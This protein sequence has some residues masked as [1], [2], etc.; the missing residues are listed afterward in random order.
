MCQSLEKAFLAKIA[1]MPPDEVELQPAAKVKSRVKPP[2]AAATTTATGAAA[3]SNNVHNLLG[4]N[5]TTPAT[6]AQSMASVKEPAASRTSSVAAPPSA[7]APAEAAGSAATAAAV[8][9]TTFPQQPLPAK[10]STT[11]MSFYFHLSVQRGNADQLCY[12]I[13]SGRVLNFK[14]YTF[15]FYVYVKGYSPLLALCSET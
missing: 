8:T 12:R 14:L 2:A 10:V 3:A 13:A 9:S 7:T 5:T 4:A 15:V 6:S 1:G 11:F